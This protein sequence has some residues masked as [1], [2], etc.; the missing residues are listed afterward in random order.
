MF[1]L[2]KIQHVFL[3]NAISAL[4]DLFAVSLHNLPLEFLFFQDNIMYVM[5][6]YRC[7]IKLGF[8][9]KWVLILFCQSLR[10]LN[11]VVQ[12]TRRQ[13]IRVEMSGTMPAQISNV[14]LFTSN[15]GVSKRINFLMWVV[16][17]RQ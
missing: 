4:P 14:K 2:F 12:R 17:N 5:F 3:D 13:K 16:C 1:C 7:C 11:G 9:L 10:R 15:S 6:T 8:K